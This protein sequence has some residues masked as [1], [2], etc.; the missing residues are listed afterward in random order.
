M[1]KNLVARL[2]KLSGQPIS[3]CK[4]LL[5]SISEDLAEKYVA[6]FEESR[7]SWFFDPVEL[8]PEFEAVRDQ[9]E[10]MVSTY[11]EEWKAQHLAELKE[12]GLEFMG[13]RAASH[14][15]AREKQ[16]LLK[17]K[18]GIN[19]KTPSQMNKNVIFH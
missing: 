9:V 16:R 10:L 15:A 4:E 12:K 19:W 18:Y 17:E 3:D 7:R 14:V 13:V 2:R 8:T 6:K 11:I 1:N 5:S